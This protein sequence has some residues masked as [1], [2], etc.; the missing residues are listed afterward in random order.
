MAATDLT[1]R[2]MQEVKGKEEEYETLR[3]LS[4]K[5]LG[6]PTG[7]TLARR[8]RHLLASGNITLIEFSDT[9]KQSLELHRPINSTGVSS[10]IAVASHTMV[11]SRYVPHESPA[12]QPRTGDSNLF[13]SPRPMSYYSDMDSSAPSLSTGY[14][15]SSAAWESQSF[16]PPFLEP[17]SG[18]QSRS[19][20]PSTHSSSLFRPLSV[21]S[22]LRPDSL[23]SIANNATAPPLP[24]KGTS[25]SFHTETIDNHYTTMSP[26]AS[27]T[28]SNLKSILKKSPSIALVSR[29][30]PKR[31]E[32]LAHIFV[33]SDILIFT[34]GGTIQAEYGSG[35]GLSLRPSKSSL[36]SLSISSGKTSKKDAKEKYAVLDDWGVARI[37]G[38]TDLSGQTG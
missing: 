10:S 15:A 7:F 17:T 9:E 35:N 4:T 12:S 13:I 26:A 11:A 32:T 30:K 2:A 6:L 34:S 25:Q 29:S 28:S 20:S 36:K 22:S 18:P 1:I 8:D 14:S 3:M 37:I 5:L 19:V 16:S 31:K 23:V 27:G 21:V 33:F 24:S 38:L